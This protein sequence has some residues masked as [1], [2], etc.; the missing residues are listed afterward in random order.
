MQSDQFQLHAEIEQVH[1]WFVAR[2][3]IV[4]QLI[5][6]ILPPEPDALVVDVGCGTGGNIAGLA[7]DYPCVGI[8]TSAEAIAL[9]RQRFPQAQFVCGWAPQDLGAKMQ[10]AKLVLLMDV[11]EHVPD[12]FAVL[13]SLLAAA[14]PGTHFLLTVPADYALWSEHDKS[15]GHYRRYDQGRLELLWAGLPVA[16]RLVSYFNARLYWPI[17]L[18]RERSRRYGRTSGRAGTDFWMPR[19]SVNRMLEAIFAGESRRLT[20]LLNG[21]C[22]K[23][24]RRGASLMAVLRREGGE[25]PV[26]QKQPGLPPDRGMGVAGHT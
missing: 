10:Q 14:A 13:S 21:R 5:G 1:W 17:R 8:D 12:D 20:G 18:I 2:R 24:Y 19:P 22:R 9:A 4:R 26:R 7:G 15:F 16:P 6:Q 25:F 23:G 3:R 11:L